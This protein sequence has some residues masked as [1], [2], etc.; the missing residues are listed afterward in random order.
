MCPPYQERVLAN[1]CDSHDRVNR[2]REHAGS[3]QCAV[4]G[5]SDAC[6]E[7][8]RAVETADGYREPDQA[9]KE[10]PG[11]DIQPPARSGPPYR[12]RALDDGKV[13]ERFHRSLAIGEPVRRVSLQPEGRGGPRGCATY[14]LRGA[15]NRKAFFLGQAWSRRPRAPA[16]F[17]KGQTV[18]SSVDES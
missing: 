6:A 9:A 18:L 17:N 10:L 15:L 11:F 3:P 4:S 16:Q 12:R 5:L 2:I 13:W 1:L 7:A 8:D 14:L